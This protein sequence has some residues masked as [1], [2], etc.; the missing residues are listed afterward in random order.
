MADLGIGDEE[1][2]ITKGN[3]IVTNGINNPTIFS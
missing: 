2:L 1:I 3:V